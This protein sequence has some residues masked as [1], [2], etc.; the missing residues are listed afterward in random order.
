[1]TTD[2]SPAPTI[3]RCSQCGIES[4]EPTC[5]TG[6]AK[7][8][9]Q[10]YAVNCITCNQPAP[11]GSTLRGV[12][13]IFG[14]ALL[15]ILLVIGFTRSKGII[16]PELLVAALIMQPLAMLLRYRANSDTELRM[17]SRREHSEP[18]VDRER[19]S[20]CRLEAV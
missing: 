18:R 12:F 7:R 14:G 1:M 10:K 9:P 2:A 19:A 15:P 6:V 4:G 3:Y 11:V 13:A 5:F 20:T 8:G 17:E 16:F